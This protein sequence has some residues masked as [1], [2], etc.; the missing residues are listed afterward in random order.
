MEKQDANRKF[1]LFHSLHEGYAVILEENQEAEGALTSMRI[2]LHTLWM[3]IM[4]NNDD[5]ALEF[6][7]RV[8]EHALDLAVEAVQV[9]AMAQKLIDSTKKEDRHEQSD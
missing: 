3:H 4:K 7:G 5:R 6:A 8:R 9:A 2:N 1:P